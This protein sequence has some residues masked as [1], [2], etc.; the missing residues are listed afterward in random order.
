MKL[1]TDLT[2]ADVQHEITHSNVY[3]FHTGAKPPT[4]ITACKKMEIQST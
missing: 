1:V 2:V 4:V 3:Y